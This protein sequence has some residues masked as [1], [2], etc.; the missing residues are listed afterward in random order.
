MPYL[1]PCVLLGD[2][3]VEL[4]VT[5]ES[6]TGWYPTDETNFPATIHPE[7]RTHMA[8]NDR[9]SLKIVRDAPARTDWDF[10]SDD[11]LVYKGI[12]GTDFD[13]DS[14]CNAHPRSDDATHAVDD[15]RGMNRLGCWKYMNWEKDAADDLQMFLYNGTNDIRVNADVL[16]SSYAVED[17]WHW[18]GGEADV[19]T[20]S[21][22]AS[23]I[24]IC[25]FGTDNAASSR[26][27]TY[28]INTF[29]A[30]LDNGYR[31]YRQ[32]LASYKEGVGEGLRIDWVQSL[33]QSGWDTFR[34]TGY[35]HDI[36]T[37]TGDYPGTASMI[38]GILSNMISYDVVPIKISGRNGR[39][40][41]TLKDAGAI[42]T[43]L[44]YN[45]YNGYVN[46][47]VPVVILGANVTQKGGKGKYVQVD[48]DMARFSGV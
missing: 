48:I 13:A 34:L 18:C 30:Y 38:G 22:E 23:D 21:S 16:G 9:R 4:E 32:N 29:V 19:G 27:F 10:D 17:V 26:T 3:G 37:S 8:V 42:K 5:S 12:Q 36:Q 14:I 6:Q 45:E 7:L 15:L 24:E 1:F 40:F 41:Q 43:Y 46:T 47:A 2:F 25:G 39:K 31:D 28:H 35:I 44:L 20:F 11:D 33:P